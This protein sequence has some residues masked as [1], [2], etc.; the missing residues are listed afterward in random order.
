MRE[1]DRV[2]VG[3]QLVEDLDAQSE[4]QPVSQS[5]P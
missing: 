5:I 3:Q 2:T 1:A 4:L